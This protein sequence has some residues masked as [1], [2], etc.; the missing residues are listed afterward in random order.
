MAT[1]SHI[2]AS[3]DPGNGV[4]LVPA[5]TSIVTAVDPTEG[6][7][8]DRVR[9]RYC[10]HVGKFLEMKSVRVL[11]RSIIRKPHADGFRCPGSAAVVG[12]LYGVIASAGATFRV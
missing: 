6:T 11:A 2:E 9:R 4:E 8:E 10:T 12:Q 7:K 1:T 3:D 5:L